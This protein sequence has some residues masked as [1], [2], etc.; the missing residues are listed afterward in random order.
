M[1]M[2][3]TQRASNFSMVPDTPYLWNMHL[4]ILGKICIFYSIHDPLRQKPVTMII[5]CWQVP[6][7]SKYLTQKICSL[8]GQ[9]NYLNWQ[10]W[11]ENLEEVYLPPINGYWSYWCILYDYYNCYDCHFRNFWETNHGEVTLPI[12]WSREASLGSDSGQ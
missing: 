6:T 3:R 10:K 5:I 12:K 7:Y 2:P 11:Q 1:F 4:V 9:Q 8:G